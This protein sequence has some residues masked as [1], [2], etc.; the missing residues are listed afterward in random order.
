MSFNS[1]SPLACSIELIAYAFLR[2]SEDSLG[3]LS[4]DNAHQ[5][6]L[7]AHARLSHAL[8]ERAGTAAMS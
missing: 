3:G 4:T 8:T 6:G 5:R 7:D 1:F 2:C